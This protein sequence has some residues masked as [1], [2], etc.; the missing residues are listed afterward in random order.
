MATNFFSAN[1]PGSQRYHNQV[2]NNFY[3]S[4]AANIHLYTRIKLQSIARSKA[5]LITPVP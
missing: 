2:N 4:V 3:P 1:Q 5:K